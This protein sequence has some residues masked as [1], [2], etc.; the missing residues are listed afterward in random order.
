MKIISK[1]PIKVFLLTICIFLTLELILYP[2]KLSV[3]PI[4][5]QEYKIVDN[6]QLVPFETVWQQIWH[7][8]DKL[9]TKQQIAV[10]TYIIDYINPDF[11]DAYLVRSNAYIAEN[12]YLEAIEDLKEALKQQPH[13]ADIYY[14]LGVVYNYINNIDALDYLNKAISLDDSNAAFYFERGYTKYNAYE[15][16]S[17]DLHQARILDKNF[18]SKSYAGL[19][20]QRK[21]SAWVSSLNKG[22]LYSRCGRYKKAYDYFF[23]VANYQNLIHSFKPAYIYLEDKPAKKNYFFTEI[24]KSAINMKYYQ[25][26]IR[27]S[28]YGV[29]Q[30]DL[31]PDIVAEL[32]MWQAFAYAGNGDPASFEYARQQSISHAPQNPQ[33]YCILGDIYHVIYADYKQAEGSYK[34]SL[35]LLSDTDSAYSEILMKLAILY[36]NTNQTAKAHTLANKLITSQRQIPD[37]ENINVFENS[38]YLSYAEAYDIL[39][40]EETA[41]KYYQIALTINPEL[42]IPEKYYPTSQERLMYLPSIIID[43]DNKTS[44][45]LKE[46]NIFH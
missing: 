2:N 28:K 27:I 7:N 29:K 42:N 35:S 13:N 38:A 18:I 43:V 6:R 23:Y 5:G 30:A 14:K 33:I 34:K 11:T 24:T 39:N 9:N 12:N 8:I 26:A 22:V 20:T 25:D 10:S 44:V 41:K 46:I 19:S 40:D 36:K 3:E 15:E 17:S 31:P 21:Q 1:S 4:P 37:T 32:Y 45:A 16:S